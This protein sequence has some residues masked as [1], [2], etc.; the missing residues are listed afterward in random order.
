[1][2][3]IFD[4]RDNVGKTSIAKAFSDRHEIPYFKHQG[5]N[6]GN[7]KDESQNA[8][9]EANELYSI[10]LIAQAK[11]TCIIDR[12]Y[13]SDY[14]YSKMFRNRDRA[15]LRKVEDFLIQKIPKHLI[16][17]CH[18]DEVTAKSDDFVNVELQTVARDL[19]LEFAN[20]FSKANVL[21]LD[22]SDENL[23]KQL[24]T[25]ADHVDEI[26]NPLLEF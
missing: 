8:I 26:M 25:I 13:P 3:L 2:L 1:M 15:S 21:V 20:D 23:E 17:I 18:K 16:V 6:K 12:H 22:T 4:G 11:I 7:F 9:S 19:F 14:V 5:I 24:R 10:D